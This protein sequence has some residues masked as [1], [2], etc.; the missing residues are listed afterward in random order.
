MDQRK[1]VL[2]GSTIFMLLAGLLQ[3]YTDHSQAPT[4]PITSSNLLPNAIVLNLVQQSHD[5]NGDI[6]LQLQAEEAF[7]FEKADT[8]QLSNIA[9][10]LF[11]DGQPDWFIQSLSGLATN[12][13]ELIELSGN[14]KIQQSHQTHKE[15]TQLNTTKL[16]LSP[17]K[18]FAETQEPVTIHQGP[19][20]TRATGMV[21]DINVGTITLLSNVKS[22]YET[23]PKGQ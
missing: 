15:P 6:S 2:I 1:L 7:Q 13:N 23:K 9:L 14:V 8:T 21:V 5:N 17:K 19:S 3:W 4:A 10:T 11:K 20:V 22:H 16:M 18:K 12:N